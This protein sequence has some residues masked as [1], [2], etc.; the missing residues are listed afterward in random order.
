MY[1]ILI[2]EYNGNVSSEYDWLYLGSPRK[3]YFLSV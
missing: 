1:I 2:I 3:S